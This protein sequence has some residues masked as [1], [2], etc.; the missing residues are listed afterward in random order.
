LS[1]AERAT[2]VSIVASAKPGQFHEAD[3]KLIALYCQALSLARRT[4]EEVEADP[5]SATSS[6]L[7][8][9]GLA[10][11]RTCSLATKLRITPL[12]RA[13]GKSAFTNDEPRRMSVYDQMKLEELADD[14]DAGSA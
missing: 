2:F 5:A 12:S 8:L 1:D 13:P 11:Q 7:R 9:Y 6:L 4:G 3:A 14:D 10:T